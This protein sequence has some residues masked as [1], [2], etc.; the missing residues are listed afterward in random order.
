M[1]VLRLHLTHFW[2][3]DQF[4]W[5]YN[6][7]YLPLSIYVLTNMNQQICNVTPIWYIINLAVCNFIWYRFVDVKK[8]VNIVTFSDEEIGKRNYTYIY[9]YTYIHTYIYIYIYIY[10]YTFFFSLKKKPK[11]GYFRII[12]L[13]PSCFSFLVWTKNTKKNITGLIQT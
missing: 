13:F 4:M 10:I 7:H 8:G 2:S 12:N 3:K 9:I 11:T 6:C 1:W 5:G